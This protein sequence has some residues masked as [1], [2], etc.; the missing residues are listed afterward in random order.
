[1]YNYNIRSFF[2]YN[3]LNDVIHS[4]SRELTVPPRMPLYPDTLTQVVFNVSFLLKFIFS[5]PTFL[6]GKDL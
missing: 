2:N 1:M 3:I 4:V 6:S 5:L